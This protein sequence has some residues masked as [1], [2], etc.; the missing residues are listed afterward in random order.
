MLTN[1]SIHNFAIVKQLDIDLQQGMTAITGET[2]AGKSIAIDALGLCLGG[3]AEATAVRQ[4]AKRAEITATFHIADGTPAQQWLCQNELDSEDQCLLRRVITAE[5]RS[6]AFVNGSPVPLQQLRE[7]GGML[8]AIHGQH[9]HQSLLKAEHQR[10]LLDSEAGIQRLLADVRKHYKNY[11]TTADEIERLSNLKQQRQDRKNL[12]A[13]QLTELDEFALHEG[14]FESL[15]T[16][17]KKLSH[18]QALIEESQMGYHYLCEAEQ[19]NAAALL[20][21]TLDRLTDIVEHDAQLQPVINMLQEAVIN[22]DEAA[23]ELKHYVDSLDMDPV[24]MQQ[25]EQRYSKAI[26]LARKHNTSPERLPAYHGQLHVEYS[27]LQQDDA[28]TDELNQALQTANDAYQRAADKLHNARSK[29]AKQLQKTVTS[30]LHKMNMQ[31]AQFRIDVIKD[32]QHKLNNKGHDTIQFML[33]S[34]KGMPFERLEKAASGGELSRIGLALQVL[35]NEARSVPT[36]IFDEVD[37]GISGS[38]AAVVGELLRELGEQSFAGD[39]NNQVFCVTHLPQVA[40]KANQQMLV[41]KFSD[42]KTTETQMMPLG[43]DKRVEEVARLLAGDSV[44]ESAIAN[45]RAL[46]A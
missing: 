2:G 38:T 16:E 26:E 31:D 32:Q 27:Q 45:A 34:N 9:A 36:L 17:F 29:R 3:R 33:C 7:L 40:A 46:L 22:V 24:R 28:K 13:Y 44:T 41:T 5:G 35:G 43:E 20:K 42:S 8:V 14:E 21:T 11:K 6:R 30:K 39:K 1:L 23:T 25:V 4:G 18:G 15:E 12:L 19:G 10:S 37:T